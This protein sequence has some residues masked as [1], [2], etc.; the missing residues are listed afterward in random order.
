MWTIHRHIQLNERSQRQR[1][2]I[3][4]NSIHMKLPKYLYMHN[5][6]RGQ[7]SIVVLRRGEIRAAT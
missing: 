5:P 6:N 4:I 2:D 7:W 3:L 1:G